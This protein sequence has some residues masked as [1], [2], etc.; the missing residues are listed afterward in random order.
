MRHDFVEDDNF[1]TDMP[2]GEFIRKK[3]RLMGYNQTDMASEF[4]VRQGTWSKWEL[5]ETSPPI[6][7]ARD[8]VKRLG[9]EILI[10][11]KGGDN[12]SL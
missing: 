9:G 11:S 8:I 7:T 10:I 5:G 4:K 3:R 12:G 1:T 6:E 2:F